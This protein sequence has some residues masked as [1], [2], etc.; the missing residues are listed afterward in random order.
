MKSIEIKA[1]R[2]EMNLTQQEFANK[3]G[4]AMMTVSNWET[5]RTKPSK[6]FTKLLEGIKND[7][8]D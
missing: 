6:F 8:R 4:I 5:G 1:M 2:K 7:S 3:I